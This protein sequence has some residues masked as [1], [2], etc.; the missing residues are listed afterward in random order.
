MLEMPN[1]SFHGN[2]RQ[3]LSAQRHH[4]CKGDNSE[5]GHIHSAHF[6]GADTQHRLL[7]SWRRPL[8]ARERGCRLWTPQVMEEQSS[9]LL[10]QLRVEQDADARVLQDLHPH[11]GIVTRISR[12]CHGVSSLP[13]VALAHV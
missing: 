12:I 13:G 10:A 8:F 3:V 1:S 5:G 11:C 6:W 7:C 2:A 9:Y 4:T